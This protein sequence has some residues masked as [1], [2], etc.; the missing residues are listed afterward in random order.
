MIGFFDSKHIPPYLFHSTNH[1]TIC[2]QWV[3][4][5][6]AAVRTTHATTVWWRNYNKTH[7]HEKNKYTLS[8]NVS[9]AIHSSPLQF[10]Y[11][12]I[13]N[14]VG[15]VGTKSYEL[16][17]LSCMSPFFAH[18]RSKF[19][20]VFKYSCYVWTPLLKSYVKCKEKNSWVH[21]PAL[22]LWREC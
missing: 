12:C 11:I 9:R 10:T 5:S 22:K 16:S 17:S 3:I 14:I 20:R 19:L 2:I 13:F 1:T 18:S 21:S 15:F 7:V 4:S 8:K 6:T